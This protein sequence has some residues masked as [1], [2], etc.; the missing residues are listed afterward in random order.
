MIENILKKI[1]LKFHT[2]KKIECS[3][4]YIFYMFMCIQEP[5]FQWYTNNRSN[6]FVE[7]GNLNIRPTLTA[8][9]FGEYFLYTGTIDLHS[10]SPNE[11]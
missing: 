6:S 11:R 8:D 7:D 2:K 10:G 5:E 3:L 4:K 9:D 1:A